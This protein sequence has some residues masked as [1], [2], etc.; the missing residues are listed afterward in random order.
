MWCDQDQADVTSGVS[1][2]VGRTHVVGQ[3][4]LNKNKVMC[5]CG[6]SGDTRREAGWFREGQGRVHGSISAL[7][8]VVSLFHGWMEINRIWPVFLAFHGRSTE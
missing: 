6:S 1:D 2:D 8:S 5:V 4:T 3:D 7:G